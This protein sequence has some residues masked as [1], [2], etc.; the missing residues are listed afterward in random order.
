M[1]RLAWFGFVMRAGT[2]PAIISRLDG[3][4]ARAV[5]TDAIEERFS[6]LG[7]SPGYLD[8][9]AFAAFLRSEPARW[10]PVVRA[11]G[12]QLTL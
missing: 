12:V 8:S 4:V 3:A 11:L 5:A 1:I 2:S 10:E 6:S 7:M 9:E